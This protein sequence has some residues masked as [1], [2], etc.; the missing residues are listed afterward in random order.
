MAPPSITSTFPGTRPS[1]PPKQLTPATITARDLLRLLQQEEKTAGQDFVLV[2]LRRNDHEGGT[3][4]GSINLPAQS[5]YPTLPTLYTLFKAAGVG[6][7]IWYCGSSQG[8]G[9]RAAAWFDD[10]LQDRADSSMKSV[11]LAGG[12]KGWVGAGPECVAL[13]RGYQSGAWEE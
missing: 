4:S 13:M 2:D 8:R 7:V 3:I 10:L 9:P 12:I 1:R 6:M 11:V 5:L